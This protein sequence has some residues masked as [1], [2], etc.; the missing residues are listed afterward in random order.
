MVQEF[1]MWFGDYSPVHIVNVPDASLIDLL[2]YFTAIPAN[3]NK[4]HAGDRTVTLQHIN[5]DVTIF[6]IVADSP[7][8]WC[9]FRYIDSEKMI[10]GMGN[11]G[12]FSTFADVYVNEGR[13]QDQGCKWCPRYMKVGESVVYRNFTI[14]HY[15]EDTHVLAQVNSA[16][17]VGFTL[18]WA[19]KMNI[20]GDFG[21]TDVIR[22]IW[23]PPG[24]YPEINY[25]ALGWGRVGWGQYKPDGKTCIMPPEGQS[26]WTK[27]CSG[28]ILPDL[29][30]WPTKISGLPPK[31][32][33][34][35]V[36]SVD[37]RC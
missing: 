18:D 20:G 25:Y 23:G 4:S 12:D 6:E 37:P 36:M 3:G 9:Y 35:Q 10:Y 31:A 15:R 13:A 5:K 32:N 28:N 19:G 30:I 14:Y 17:Q 27:I 7:R 24:L 34:G 8:N 1:I 29:S 21:L 22:I 33:G 2:Q 26:W 16:P 11:T